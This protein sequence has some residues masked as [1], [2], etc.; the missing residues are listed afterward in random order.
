MQNANAKVKVKADS[1]RRADEGAKEQEKKEKH[2]SDRLH[3]CGW[4][5]VHAAERDVQSASHC[6][7]GALARYI[8]LE[9][10]Q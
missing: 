8:L 7:R 5:R 10:S 4:G 1:G 9:I 6:Y 3:T 2:Q